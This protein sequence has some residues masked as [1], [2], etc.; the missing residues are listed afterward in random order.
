MTKFGGWTLNKTLRTVNLGAELEKLFRTATDADEEYEY[1]PLEYLG[2]RVTK[3]VD[4][5][6]LAY[7]SKN[8]EVVDIVILNVNVDL[9][10]NINI[11]KKISSCME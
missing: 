8:N 1:D 6:F 9:D 7:V 3:S 11:T 4:Y 2:C 10:G 5:R